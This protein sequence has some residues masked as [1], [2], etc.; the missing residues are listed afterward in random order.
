LASIALCAVVFL[1]GATIGLVSGSDNDDVAGA[2]AAETCDNVASIGTCENNNGDALGDEI[3]PLLEKPTEFVSS[4][5]PEIRLAVRRWIP[6]ED[7]K[8][9]VVIHHGGA[10][11]H[12]GWFDGL[13]NFL[14]E[15]GIGVIAYDMVG[16]GFS[17]AI[18]GRRHYFDS[19][20]RVADD[21]TTLV[22]D[23]REKYPGKPVFV[24]AESFG[25]MVALHSILKNQTT[26]NMVADGYI[27]TGPVITVREEMLPPKIVIRIVKF[28]ARFF[29]KMKMPG[30]DI[31]STFDEA[32]GDPR[33]A[34]AGRA[35]PIV[36]EWFGTTPLLDMAV[37]ALTVSESN[38]RSMDQV[39]V[40]ISVMVGDGD[41]RINIPESKLL[42]KVAKSKDKR[43]KLYENAR[44][45]LFQD[46]PEISREA[47][48]DVKD[49]I[50]ARST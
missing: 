34:K 44:H 8:S 9:L 4:S 22:K 33:W 6:D 42:I 16:V 27:L 15:H 26:K 28:L 39:D 24:L 14:M 35:D 11:M 36:Q 37:S 38:K 1:S 50:L 31:A 45:M 25:G 3:G 19:I 49:W 30:T 13:G 32:F 21:L 48:N 5:T 46:K 20:D 47:M 2:D 7:V 41:V 43:F 40:P 12:S 10:G 17:D 18:G 29:P 23:T